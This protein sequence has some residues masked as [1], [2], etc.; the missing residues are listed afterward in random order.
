[1][2]TPVIEISQT[3]KET[4]IKVDAGYKKVISIDLDNG[5]LVIILQG[6]K[7]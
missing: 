2:L 4:N 3:E 7:E 6:K 5:N 1:M